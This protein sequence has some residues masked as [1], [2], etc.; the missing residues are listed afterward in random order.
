M[1]ANYFYSLFVFVG[2]ILGINTNMYGITYANTVNVPTAGTLSSILSQEQKD[3]ITSLKLTG[4]LDSSTYYYGDFGTL[5]AMKNLQYLDLSG[6]TII[7]NTMP[8]S[9]FYYNSSL[10][11]I[12]FPANLQKIDDY[13]FYNCASLS[14][15]LI[16]PSSLTSF[17]TYAFYNCKSLSGELTFPSS[18]TNIGD[19]AFNNCTSLS[20][21]LTFPSSLANIGNYAFQNCSSLTK[22]NF[23]EGLKTIGNNAFENCYGLSGQL[24]LPSSL[25]NIGSYAFRNCSSLS[26]ELVLLSSLVNIGDC[27]FQY[28]SSL[29]KVSFSEGLETIGNNAFENCYGLSGELALPS[30]LTQI[31]SYAFNGCNKLTTCKSLAVVPPTAINYSYNSLGNIKAVFV[32]DASISAY[33]SADFWKDKIIMGGTPVSVEINLTTAGT[34]GEKILEQVSFV[35][36]VNIL[37]ISGPLNTTDFNR[38]KDDMNSLISVDLSGCVNTELPDNLFNGKGGLLDVK[39]PVNLTKIGSSVFAYCYALAVPEFPSTLEEIGNSAFYYCNNFYALNFPNS[40]KTIGDYAFEYCT[41]LTSVSF[42]NSLTSI[43]YAAFAYCY[44]LQSVVIPNS[45]SS[46]GGLAFAYCN[47]LNQVTIPDNLARIENSTFYNCTSLST[48][49]LPSALTYLGSS[50]FSNCPLAQATLPSGLTSIDGSAFGYCSNLQKITCLQSTPPVLNS[51][52]FYGIDKSQCELA[53][54]FWAETAYKLANV[55]KQFTDVSTYNT[56]IT[57]LS[58]NSELIFG[59]GVRPLGNPNVTLLATGDFTVQG[60]DAFNIKKYTQIQQFNY[61]DAYWNYIPQAFSSLI[62]ESSAMRADSVIINIAGISGGQWQFISLPFDAKVSDIEVTPGVLYAIRKYDGATRATMGAGNSWKNMTPDSTMRAN[63]GY[64]VQFNKSADK[65]I[66]KAINNGNKN[67]IFSNAAQNITLQEY[68][69]EFAQNRS[70]N[71][72]GNPFPSYF[73][74]RYIDYNAPI[75]VRDGSNYLALSL[76]DDDYVL[77]PFQAFFVQKPVETNAIVFNLIGRQIDATIAPRA[78]LKSASSRTLYNLTLSNDNYS[79]KTRIVI[80]PEANMDYEI[81]RDASKFMSDDV[82]I[83]QLFSLDNSQIQYAINE[84]PLNDGIVPLGIYIGEAGNY[85]LS[86]NSSTLGDQEVI[87]VDKLLNNKETTLSAA[88][89]MFDSEEGIFTNR[90]ELHISRAATGINTLTKDLVKV[91]STGKEITVEAA[92]GSEITVLSLTGQVLRKMVAVQNR[93]DFAV[94][95]PGAYIVVVNQKSLKVIVSK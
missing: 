49:Q 71:F 37:K 42:Q 6:V 92:I 13:A 48:I 56:E 87:L 88:N 68:T 60:D 63:Q 72:I 4:F 20:G 21:G 84:R 75:T 73:D 16:L 39:L 8:S 77:T 18:L 25:A 59:S 50:A 93:V 89:Y 46:I 23:S 43:G 15:E 80:N 66:V 41:N 30:T 79:D 10:K 55:W 36:D 1:K 64:I 12:I 22:V 38:I 90:F 57:D 33:K 27:T 78:D 19:G 67:K 61:Y 40:L 69:S 62:S 81:E 94:E 5:N 58:I 45:V 74:I 95:Q 70:W 2:M 53:V 3:T 47:T 11:G 26:G 31:G 65:F 51:D 76:T 83:P 7:N 82:K 91:F 54:P 9:A 17:G 52:P 29:A 44:S 28:C 14:E 85:S 35:N 24:T 86:L 34:L 32:P